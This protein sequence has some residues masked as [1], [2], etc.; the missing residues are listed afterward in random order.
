MNIGFCM[1]GSFCTFHRAEEV[2]KKLVEHGAQV[3]P[4]LSFNAASLDTRFGTAAELKFRLETL[5]GRSIIDSIPK[6]EPIGPKKM[7]DVLLV[8]PC[9]GNTLAKL[10]YGITDT[11]VC[12]AVKSH[13]RNGRPV[14]IAVATNDGLSGSGKNIGHLLNYKNMYFVP[15]SQDDPENKPRSLVADFTKVEDT[16]RLALEGKQLGPIFF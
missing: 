8:C 10:A 3:T 12:M 14:V 5:T 6:A 11:P 2:L 15:L 16:I 7:F 4:I 13:V 9:T 1:T